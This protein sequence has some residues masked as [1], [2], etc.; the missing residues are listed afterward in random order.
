MGLSRKMV[1]GPIL[2]YRKY[3]SP[4]KPPT[5]R[6]YPT[7]S[8]YAMEAVEVHGA[9]KGS[10]LAAKRIA[11]CQPFHPGGLDPVPPRKEK[12]DKRPQEGSSH[13]T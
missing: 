10:W 6:F 8:A 9:L 11:K 13:L 3:I 12:R 4:L 7:C 1:Q 2:F 5:C